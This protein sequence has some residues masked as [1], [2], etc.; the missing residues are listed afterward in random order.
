METKVKA[1][2]EKEISLLLTKII[3]KKEEKDKDNKHF[4]RYNKCWGYRWKDNRYWRYI[5]SKHSQRNKRSRWWIT[6]ADI[7]K[8]TTKIEDII[9]YTTG[10]SAE[11][12]KVLNPKTESSITKDLDRDITKA[13]D[14][15]KLVRSGMSSTKSAGVDKT[16]IFHEW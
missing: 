3:L 5:Y 12:G 8:G 2:I 10:I 4:S 11:T 9:S 15:S 6:A 13:D 1:R 14:V 7:A 16:N